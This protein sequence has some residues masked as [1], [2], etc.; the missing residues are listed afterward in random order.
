MRCANCGSSLER[1]WRYCPACGSEQSKDAFAGIFDFSGIIERM[2]REFREMDD[3]EQK[4]MEI[5][6]LMPEMK[7]SNVAGFSI[8]ISQD[9]EGQPK[10][11]VRTFGDVKKEDVEKSL[12]VTTGA[13]GLEFEPLEE[14]PRKRAKR[15]PK[16]TE[17]P[18]TQ[19]RRNGNKITVEIELPGVSEKKIEIKK[20]TESVEV[21]A[22]SGNKAFF[23][24]LTLP[25]GFELGGKEFSNGKLRMEFLL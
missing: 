23:K 13:G 3:V 10:V 22:V 2:N 9:G 12:K 20:L 1:K 7:K 17:E 5:F 4:D 21:K 14:E 25:K 6:N 15:A 18:E 16:A 11:S 8:N 19:V 24:I